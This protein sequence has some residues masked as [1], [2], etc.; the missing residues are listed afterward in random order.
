MTKNSKILVIVFLSLLT[1]A[2]SRYDEGKVRIFN[3][4][5]FHYVMGGSSPVE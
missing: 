3:R 5:N 4:N 1:L 2:N